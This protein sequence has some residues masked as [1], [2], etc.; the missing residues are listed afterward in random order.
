MYDLFIY[1]LHADQR[2]DPNADISK[3]PSMSHTGHGPLTPA[4]RGELKAS[5]WHATGDAADTVDGKKNQQQHIW[6][7]NEFDIKDDW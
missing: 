5:K 1:L 2:I 3:L 6:A 4:V 7:L